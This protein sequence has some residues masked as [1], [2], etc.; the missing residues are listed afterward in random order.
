MK[1]S[2]DKRLILFRL[3]QPDRAAAQ[4]AGDN[5]L[6]VIGLVVHIPADFT[7]EG[8]VFSRIRPQAV[9]GTHAAHSFSNCC[10]ASSMAVL[11]VGWGRLV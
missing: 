2:A 5:G 1:K 7:E 9:P 10:M 11:A 8:E 3:A 4:I 6:L